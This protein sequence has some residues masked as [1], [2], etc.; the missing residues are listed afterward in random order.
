MEDREPIF[1]QEQAEQILDGKADPVWVAS[2][3]YWRGVKDGQAAAAPLVD[4]RS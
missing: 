4:A 2:Q 1:T 3:A